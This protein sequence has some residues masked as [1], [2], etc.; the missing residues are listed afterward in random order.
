MTK[1]HLSYRSTYGEI[2]KRHKIN[3]LPLY[4]LVL[5]KGTETLHETGSVPWQ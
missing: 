3:C 2:C 1:G 4:L 5:L